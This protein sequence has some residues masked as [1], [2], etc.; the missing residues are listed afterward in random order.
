MQIGENELHLIR[1]LPKPVFF[2]I[3]T[4]VGLA[5]FARMA[6]PPLESVMNYGPNVAA[7]AKIF[8]I[9]IAFMPAPG[10]FIAFLVYLYVA[11]RDARR[12][13]H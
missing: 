6:L 5:L 1:T 13:S 7:V 8:G 4:G 11:Y 10:G 3:A 2:G 9:V 12:D